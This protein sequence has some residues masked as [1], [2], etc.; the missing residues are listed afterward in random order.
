M[1]HFL[2][3]LVAKKGIFYGLLIGVMKVMKDVRDGKLIWVT[4]LTDLAGSILIGYVAYE[5]VSLTEISEL[6]KVVWTIFMA[7]NAFL[8]IAI[9]SDKKLFQ[10]IVDKYIK[11]I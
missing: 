7:S 8:V 3:V 5:I 11:K 6:M 9:L 2:T 1:E 10:K 4:A